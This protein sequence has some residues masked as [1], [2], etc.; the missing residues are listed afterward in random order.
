MCGSTFIDRNFDAWMIK[1]F[2]T[3]YTKLSPH[4]RGT[5]SHFFRQFETAKKNFTG[6]NHTKR[7]DVWPINMSTGKSP[8]YDKRNFTVKLQRYV[9]CDRRGMRSNCES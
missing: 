8:S 2:G 3:A 4:E 6:P 7:L 5:S 1:K 9:R